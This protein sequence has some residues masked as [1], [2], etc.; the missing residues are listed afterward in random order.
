MTDTKIDK[1]DMIFELRKQFIKELNDKKQ[2]YQNVPLLSLT[3]KNSQIILRDHIIKAA[4]ELFEANQELKNSKTHRESQI[5]EF[6]K[7]AYVE[8]LVDALNFIF[9][10][11]ILSDIS[12]EELL[13]AYERKH[14]III[15]RIKN[16]Y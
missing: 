14:K 15:E 7:S 8:E 9:S 1:L 13:D 5:T 11:L 2:C 16:N 12:S 10:A 6:N 3:D 4:E